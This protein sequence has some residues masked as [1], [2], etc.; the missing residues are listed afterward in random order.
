MTQ[1][2]ITPNGE[3]ARPDLKDHLKAGLLLS[4]PDM[5]LVGLADGTASGAPVVMAFLT[6]PD[7]RT[8][9]AETTLALF[10]TAADALKARYGDPR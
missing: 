1:L 8:V 4:A 7:G 6:L 5:E 10:L 9:M 2:K 3:G